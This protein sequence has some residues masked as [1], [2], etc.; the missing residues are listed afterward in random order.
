M[1]ED[2]GKGGSEEWESDVSEEELSETEDK[3][4]EFVREHA[5]EIS[6]DGNVMNIIISTFTRLHHE[7][8]SMTKALLGTYPVTFKKYRLPKVGDFV[9][10]SVKVVVVRLFI[11]T[12]RIR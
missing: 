11:G 7:C 3:Y 1:G 2:S 6:T 10:V 9:A 12:Q 4:V 5:H 8:V